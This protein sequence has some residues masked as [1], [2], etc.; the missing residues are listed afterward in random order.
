M[1]GSSAAYLSTS[2]VGNTADNNLMSQLINISQQLQRVMKEQA[3]V[4]SWS[5][6][7]EVTMF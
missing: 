1:I 5:I 7:E 4:G 2:M 6:Q 3:S